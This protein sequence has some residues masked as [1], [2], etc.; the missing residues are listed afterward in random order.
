[1]GSNKGICGFGFFP[2]LL[3]AF[4]LSGCA[5]PS[6]V[7]D[8]RAD[9]TLN[10]DLHGQSYSVMVRMYQLK[11]AEEFQQADYQL[12]LEQGSSVLGTSLLKQEEFIVEPGEHQR[13]EFLREDGAQYHG[14]VA[15]FRRVD[16]EHW[17]ASGKLK[18]GLL[19]PMTTHSELKLKNTQIDLA[20]TH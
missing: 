10:P 20:R 19:R 7:L 1:M 16:G 18:N 4:F 9:E 14:V 11:T 2:I 8:I 12:L 3:F 15:F 13:L 6:I 17:R 5:T